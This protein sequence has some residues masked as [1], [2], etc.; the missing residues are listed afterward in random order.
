M[1]SPSSDIKI[2][3]QGGEPTLNWEALTYFVTEGERRIRQQGNR[4]LSFVVCT[5]LIDLSAEQL[6]FLKEHNVSISSSCDGPAYFH[7]L[8]R[9]AR[10]G[11]SSYK[12]FI[13]N[14]TIV[15]SEMGL[16]S[17]SAL[18][19]VTKDNLQYL[20]EVIDHYVALDFKSVFIRALNPYGYAQKNEESLSYSTEEFLKQYKLALQ[21]IF[22]LN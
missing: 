2:E 1:S 20:Q 7:D 17:V 19:T 10:D 16:D 11:S 15:R 9:K 21:Y 22:K 5:N 6:S 4:Q 12:H 8:H 13:D 14:L 18:L 3:F